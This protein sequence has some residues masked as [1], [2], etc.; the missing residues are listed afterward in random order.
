MCAEED[1][2]G[3]GRLVI[4]GLAGGPSYI[5]VNLGSKQTILTMI[6]VTG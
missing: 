2:V 5:V 6:R 1:L 3:Y 4:L